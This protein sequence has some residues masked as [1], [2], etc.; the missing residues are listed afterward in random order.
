MVQPRGRD[1]EDHTA[2][3]IPFGAAACRRGGAGR[4]D[5][6]Y[7]DRRHRWRPTRRDRR[8][9]GRGAGRPPRGG[10]RRR[11][12][13]CVPGAPAGRLHRHVH[14]GRL[15]AAGARR[16][17]GRGPHGHRRR[18]PAARGTLRGGHRGGD[19]DRHRGAGHQHAPR[20]DRGQPRDAGA[21]GGHAARRPFPEPER[22]P[23]RG[24]RAEQ[25]VQL[26]PA[27]DPHRER[28]QRQ[29]AGP[30]RV[31]DAGADQRP[32]PRAGARAPDRGTLRRRQ[33]DPRHRRRPARGDEGGRLGDVRLRRGRRCR[34]LRDTQRL[35]GAS[36]STSRTTTSTAAAIP[37]S[38]ASGA[39]G[40]GTPARS[41]PRSG[42]AARSCRWRSARGRSIV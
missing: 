8:G 6:R 40:S 4:R 18:R 41:S 42:S 15:R 39:A 10:D 7:G 26:E 35:P 27:V 28:G 25:L 11:R 37:R 14:A 1:H 23:R 20:G 2:D 12:P 29:P 22:Q 13:V 17:A 9:V 3:G 36:S 32:P 30:G 5:F 19:R 16:R 24:R 38:P 31:A 21:A 33:H 34:Q